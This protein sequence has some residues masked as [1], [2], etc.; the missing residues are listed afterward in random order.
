[1][2]QFQEILKNKTEKEALEILA[3]FTRSAF[4][5][6]ND[7]DYFGKNKPMIGDEVFYYP[8]SDCEDRSALFYY[9]VNELL[10]LPMIV[11]AYDDHLTI[12]VATSRSLG[13]A[14]Y[15]KNKKYYICDPTGPSN[16]EKIG[17]APVGYTHQK[18]EILE[19]K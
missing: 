8:Y 19:V 18:F 15:F 10:R 2:P 6:K 17:K 11:I 5:Y 12:A 16:S 4:Q 1:L 9:L 13:D 14:I 7:N 3:S